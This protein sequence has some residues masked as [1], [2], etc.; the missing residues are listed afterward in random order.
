MQLTIEGVNLN[1]TCAGQGTDVVLLHG[2]PFSH[3]IWKKQIETLALQWRVIAPDLRGMGESSAPP[4]PYLME[5]LAS[6]VAGI[7]DAL[8]VECAA[9]VGHSMGGYAALAFFRMFAERVRSLALVCSRPDADTPQ[10]AADRADLAERAEREG[11][12]PVIEAYLPRVLAPDARPDVIATVTQIMR[13]SSAAGAAALLRGAALRS[14]SEDLLDELSL[15]VL[16]V[17][18]SVDTIS[19]PEFNRSLA[20]RLAQATVA[21]VGGSAHLP[22]LES[23]E[24]L[25]AILKEFLSRSGSATA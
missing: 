5:T 2:F 6:D 11:M 16:L 15:P 13:T 3:R 10:A 25:S 23:P 18:G 12:Q 20:A 7:L 4:G 24:T 1:V 17:C 8:D 9:I 19:P 14:S 22:M 21:V